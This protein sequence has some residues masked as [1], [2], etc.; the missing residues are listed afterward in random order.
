MVGRFWEC[1]GM[2]VVGS[3]RR[4]LTNGRH[5]GRK[6]TASTSSGTRAL[7]VFCARCQPRQAA[8]AVRRHSGRRPRRHN[9]EPRRV[10]D[11]HHRGRGRRWSGGRRGWSG[12]RVRSEWRR[13]LKQ[14]HRRRAARSGLAQQVSNHRGETA[15]SRPPP[16]KSLAAEPTTTAAAAAAAATTAAVAATTATATTA[17]AATTATAATSTT[18]TH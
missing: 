18:A 10:K 5:S 3:V 9:R 6:G 12:Q 1:V 13:R 8:R 4:G 17:A 11:Q 15:G 7:I 14:L 2:V 16:H